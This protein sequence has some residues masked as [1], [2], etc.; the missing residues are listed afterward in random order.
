MINFMVLTSHERIIEPTYLGRTATFSVA[1]NSSALTKRRRQSEPSSSLTDAAS[2]CG[3]ALEKSRHTELR[4]KAVQLPIPRLKLAAVELRAASCSWAEGTRM[5][6][7]RL[8]Q[9][10]KLRPDEIKML[11]RAF[12]H[13]LRLL[14]LVDRRDDP[15]AEMVA[16]KIIEVGTIDVRDPAEISRIAVKQLGLSPE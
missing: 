12:D 5:P 7:R 11:T 3:T 9:D 10:S 4:S 2:N 14:S 6:I 13:A 16:R 8:I 15:L 1:S